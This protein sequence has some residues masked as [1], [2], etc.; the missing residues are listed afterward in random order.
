[1]GRYKP[2]ENGNKTVL[3]PLY[4]YKVK[5]GLRYLFRAI[6]IGIESCP[7]EISVQNHT[8]LVIA[9]DV[10]SIQPLEVDSLVIF[11]GERF[12]FVINANQKPGTYF[13]KYKGLRRCEIS[14]AHQLECASGDLKTFYTVADMRISPNNKEDLTKYATK[15]D[16]KF[17][18]EFDLYAINNEK[19][20]HRGVFNFSGVDEDFRVKV[21]LMNFISFRL[22][23]VP[24]LSQPN[25]VNQTLYCNSSTISNSNCETE[26]CRCTHVLNVELGSLVEIILT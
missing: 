6:S 12:D 26:F 4:E 25:E 11:G 24:P 18:I 10:K 9:S 8:L 13:I 20:F 21:P 2:L 1:M 16:H 19:W 7:I 23:N 3:T 14:S 5:Q 15:P 22:P 17:F